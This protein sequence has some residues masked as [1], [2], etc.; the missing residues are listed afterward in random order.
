MDIFYIDTESGKVAIANTM[1]VATR[2]GAGRMVEEEVGADFTQA[3]EK[4]WIPPYGAPKMLHFEEARPFNSEEL[5]K[6]LE[7]HK[8]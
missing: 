5:K 1:D 4:A 6:F 8:I 3:L 7:L 2:F